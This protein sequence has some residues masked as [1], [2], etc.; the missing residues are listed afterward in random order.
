M[1]YLVFNKKADNGHGCCTAKEKAKELE[2]YFGEFKM[3]DSNE[4]DL[5]EFSK[6]LTDMDSLVLCGG[7]GTINYFINHV[8]DLDNLPYQFYFVES[9]TGN[10]CVRDIEIDLEKGCYHIND[11][12][13]GLPVVEVKGQKYR[14]VNGIGFG[15][16][17]ECCKKADELKE[18]GAKKIDYTGITVKLLLFKYKAPNA[19]VV[20]DDGE[21]L[22]YKKT[23][24]ASVM[25]GQFYGG[26]MQ[27]APEQKRNS[28]EL[29]FVVLSGTNRVNALMNFPSIFKGELVKKTKICQ[30]HKCKKATVKFDHPTALQIDGETIKDVLEYSVSF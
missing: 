17:G 27:V 11:Y 12:V 14:F 19:T 4:V 18:K 10:D 2:K 30:A 22:H 29:S 15:I 7:D 1:N 21:E 9:G 8:E 26:G 3:I 28:K 13:K 23:Y 24:L 20:L 6:G 5:N 16:D 25:N